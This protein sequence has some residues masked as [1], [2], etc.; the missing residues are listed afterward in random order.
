M[1][2]LVAVLFL[3]SLGFA[4]TNFSGVYVTQGRAGDVIL[5]IQQSEDALLTGTVAGNGVSYNLSGYTDET[6]GFGTLEADEFATFMVTLGASPEELIFTLTDNKGEQPFTFI[7]QGD[8]PAM[9][10]ENP[11]S[12]GT[13]DAWTGLFNNAEATRGLMISAVNNSEYTGTLIIDGFEY[14]FSATGD[15]TSLSGN[16]VVGGDALVPFTATKD[17]DS[18]MLSFPDSGESVDLTKAF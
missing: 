14:P 2:Y 15:E 6:S 17:G 1:K 8:V 3:F 13:D 5:T 10:E 7:R 9:T 12:P 4:Q 11:L 18:V 16:Y